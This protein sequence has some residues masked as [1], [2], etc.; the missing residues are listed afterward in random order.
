MISSVNIFVDTH[1]VRL[2]HDK[3]DK[4]VF[5]RRSKRLMERFR[6][7]E[8]FTYVMFQGILSDEHA[9]TS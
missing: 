2:D 3:I 8:A 1:R 7:K 6:Q 4:I 5:L 9:S